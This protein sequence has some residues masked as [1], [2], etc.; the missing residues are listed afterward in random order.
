MTIAPC[1][2]CACTE[3]L[4]TRRGISA[5]GSYGPDLLPGAGGWFSGG[6][7]KLV[8]CSECGFVRF[9][10]GETELENIKK[11]TRWRKVE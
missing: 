8:V 5:R 4:E 10:T 7:F 6:R 11:S 9:F 3:L 1:P 2:N